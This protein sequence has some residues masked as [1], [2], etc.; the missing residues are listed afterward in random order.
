MLGRCFVAVVDTYR[1]M[2]QSRGFPSIMWV[3]LIQSA[4]RSSEQSQISTGRRD[5]AAVSCCLNPR[6]ALRFQTGSCPRVLK[7]SLSTSLSP[8]PSVS[9]P[10]SI[11]SSVYFSVS[12][13]YLCLFISISISLFSCLFISVSVISP[14]P[15]SDSLE[16]LT[17]T[18]S[19]L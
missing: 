18:G 6:P 14:L 16:N 8:S 5:S 11:S 4:E 2:S 12:S 1:K 13:L 9:P 3:A 17:D 7:I 10:I 15:G 19:Y